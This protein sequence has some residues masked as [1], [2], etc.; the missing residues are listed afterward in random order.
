MASYRGEPE[1]SDFE[2]VARLD[3]VPP[4]QVIRVEVDGRGL[5]LVN[6]DG[7]FYAIDNNCQHN[8]GPLAQGRL[9]TRRGELIC[10]WHAWCWDVRSGRAMDPPVNFRALTYEVR[11]EG[12]DVLVSRSPR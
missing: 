1:E 12:E 7:I 5:A 10:P 8:G 4:G 2:R 3:E 6:L 9:D 11:L